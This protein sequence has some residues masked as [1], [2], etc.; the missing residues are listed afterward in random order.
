[1]KNKTRKEFYRIIRE[2]KPD[3]I[4]ISKINNDSIYMIR[5]NGGSICSDRDSQ[6]MIFSLYFK[7]GNHIHT[8]FRLNYSVSWF[9]Y[10]LLFIGIICFISSAIIAGFIISLISFALLSFYYYKIKVYYWNLIYKFNKKAKKVDSE[11]VKKDS[12]KVSIK[13]NK[14]IKKDVDKGKKLF[15]IN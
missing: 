14:L 6:D 8:F 12:T 13:S 9:A 11:K 3:D 10:F 4:S 15:F 5:Y 2:S 7:D 1:M